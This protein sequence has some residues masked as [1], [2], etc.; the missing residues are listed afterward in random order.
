MSRPFREGQVPRTSRMPVCDCLCPGPATSVLRGQT[1]YLG[2]A[3]ERVPEQPAEAGQSQLQLTAAHLDTEQ[4]SS[5][6]GAPQPAAEH[7]SC[8]A[9]K[10]S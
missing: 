10:H 3:A 2:V 7:L 6:S 8:M 5:A 1:A 4:V 9:R